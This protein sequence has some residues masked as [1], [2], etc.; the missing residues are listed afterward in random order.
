MGLFSDE[1]S[2]CSCCDDKKAV[3]FYAHEDLLKRLPGIDRQKQ[4]KIMLAGYKGVFLRHVSK[5]IT[6]QRLKNSKKREE[7]EDCIDFCYICCRIMTLRPT[8]VDDMLR[9]AP[10]LDPTVQ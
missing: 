4:G 8:D 10:A 9:Y 5:A 2:C 1:G 6:K 7:E 3:Q